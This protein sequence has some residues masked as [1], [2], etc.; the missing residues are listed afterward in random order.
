MQKRIWNGRVLEG[1]TLGALMLAALG[2]FPA[3]AGAI[4]FNMEVREVT[5]TFTRYVYGCGYPCQL[6]PAQHDSLVAPAG[7]EVAPTRVMLFDSGST[8][9][10]T[11]PT[12]VAPTLD[13]FPG[14]AGP[15][16]TYI[17]EVLGAT[18]LQ[19][20]GSVG[21][22]HVIAQVQRDTSFTYDAGTVVHEAT[23]TSGNTYVLFNIPYTLYQT[24]DVFQEGAMAAF[25]LPTGW[26]YSS[27][28][29]TSDLVVASGGEATVYA[30]G[31]VGT[32][33]MLVPEP[34]IL[35]LLAV[36]LLVVAA[37]RSR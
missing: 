24:I 9:L 17:A 16:Y 18:F 12:G 34:S 28:T 7:F 8:N 35:S 21:G 4:I 29:L 32:W 22:A 37:A 27:R 33:Q 26:T 30:Q 11:P 1:A 5:G 13:L 3:D 25:N 31:T 20:D 19:L 36:G 14:V 23:D 10:P 6:T 15:E 2:G